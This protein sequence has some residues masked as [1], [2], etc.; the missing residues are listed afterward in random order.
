MAFKNISIVGLGLIGGSI[1]KA[2]KLKNSSLFI[3]AY[4]RES[5]CAAALT[6]KIIDNPLSDYKQA[7]DSELIILA[8]PIEESLKAF[9]ELAPLLRQGCVL[10][11]VCSVKGIFESAWRDVKSKGVYIGGHPMAGKESGGYEN[12]DPY[13]F[14]NAVYVISDRTAGIPEA[15]GLI[16]L[17]EM[18]GARIKFLD[19]YL[20][21]KAAAYISHLPQTLAVSLVNCL[22][23]S[24]DK[25]NFISLAGGGF[26]D[27]TRIAS[28]DFAIWE[29]IYKYNKGEIL[30]SIEKLQELL[31]EYSR[32]IKS[33]DFEKLH[34]EFISSS[35]TR[36]SI[37]KNAKGFLRPL[38]DVFVFAKDEPGAISKM[39]SILFSKNINIKDIELL[40]IREGEGGAFRLGFASKEEADKAKAALKDDGFRLT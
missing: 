26:R 31:A 2:L 23:D 4:D 25:V 33:E 1:A 7:L 32:L 29:S 9:K 11:D 16:P 22:P 15:D 24:S 28:S 20:H 36:N 14:E 17:I 30:N 37:P 13:L 18:L 34:G 21:D 6:E 10:T 12:S 27:M 35:R 8:L 3:N 19:P 39:S 5:V 38:Y 40:K